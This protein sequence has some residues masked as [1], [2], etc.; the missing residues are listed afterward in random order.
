MPSRVGIDNIVL[1]CTEYMKRYIRNQYVIVARLA[2]YS[3][4]GWMQCFISRE[5]YERLAKYNFIEK[6]KI[7]MMMGAPD[8]AYPSV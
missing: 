7:I 4:L 1:D 8:A 2:S 3:Q 5:R 6:L